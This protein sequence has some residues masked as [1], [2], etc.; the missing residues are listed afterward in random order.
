MNCASCGKS[1]L[2]IYAKDSYLRLP[3]YHCRECNLFITGTSESQLRD[4]LK[5]YYSKS[6]LP[7]EV[8]KIMD[9]DYESKVGNYLKNLW[10][11]QHAYCKP[12][13]QISKSLLEIGPGTGIS[14]KMFEELGYNVTGVESNKNYVDFINRKLQKGHCILGFIEEV[15]LDKKFDTIWLS[16]CLE[17]V[18]NPHLLLRQCENF[19]SDNGFIFIAVPDCENIDTLKASIYD[20]ASSFH[21]S[22]KAL[23]KIVNNAGFK[24]IRCESIRDLSQTERRLHR[25]LRRTKYL[26]FLSEKICPYYPFQVTNKT[27]GVE[28]RMVL[29]KR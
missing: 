1:S 21:F 27:N 13:Y 7:E 22:K 19:L 17:H 10:Q 18:P 28:I 6:V 2:V 26:G 16:H 25:I 24:V 9:L 14:L 20:N 23:I 3:V 29:K 5:N 8:K 12:Y 4:I 15:H 11:S